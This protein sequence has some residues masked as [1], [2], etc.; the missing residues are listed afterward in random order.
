[1]RFSHVSLILSVALTAHAQNTDQCPKTNPVMD[2][3]TLRYHCCRAGYQHNGVDCVP[4]TP[5]D[6]YYNPTTQQCERPS[7]PEDQVFFWSLGDCD[8]RERCKPWGYYNGRDCEPNPYCLNDYYWDAEKGCTPPPCLPGQVYLPHLPDCVEKQY[9]DPNENKVYIPWK[10]ECETCRPDEYASP[11]GCQP[12][13]KC[14]NPEHYYQGPVKHCAPCPDPNTFWD[15]STCQP[16][17]DCNPGEHRQGRSCVPNDCK[18]GEY[19][20]KKKNQ[21]LPVHKCEV[22]WIFDGV[23]DCIPIKYPDEGGYI[24]YTKCDRPGPLPKA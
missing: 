4:C 2:P 1:M 13:P 22:G 8:H 20:D 6:E 10:N 24:C 9:C 19:W 21:C 11:T 23:D 7:C 15:G 17:P 18:I 12:R 5:P 3:V 16:L 14:L